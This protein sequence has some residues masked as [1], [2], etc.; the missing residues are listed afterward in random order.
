MGNSNTVASTS[1]EIPPSPSSSAETVELE[2]EKSKISIWWDIQNCKV[3]L[4][5]DPHSIAQ[6]LTSALVNMKYC[7]PV[8][9]S[10]YGDTNRLPASVHQAL[11]I[12]GI[13]LNHVSAG[14]KDASYKKMLMDML[15]WAL[16]NPAPANYL[17]ISGD[18]DFSN[19]L[20]QLRMRRYNIL[21]AQPTKA[22]APL[23]AAATSVWLWAT[24]CAGGPPLTKDE[25]SQLVQIQSNCLSETD[26]KPD[27]LL[28]DGRTSETRQKGKQTSD[29]LLNDGR[30]SETRQKGKQRCLPESKSEQKSFNQIPSHVKGPVMDK[31]SQK[32]NK[33]PNDLVEGQIAVILFALETLK[34][35]MIMPTDE[36]LSDCIRYG[37]PRHR[38]TDVKKAIESA[39]DL[40]FVVKKSLGNSLQ[41]YVGKNDKLW[42]CVNLWGHKQYPLPTWREVKK[43][44]L[45][46]DGRS[47]I[48]ASECKYEAAIIIKRMCLKEHPL[49]EIL[50]IVQL[51]VR[52]KKWIVHNPSGWQPVSIQLEDHVVYL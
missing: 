13:T 45:S 22:S 12:T 51:M 36:N 52:A 15:F 35:E 3:P 42:N 33:H 10:V 50:H 14:V 1:G 28:N 38:N 7:G 49:G 47:A 37:D 18:Q 11:N 24:L 48:M 43:F 44:M 41:L 30:T 40:Q 5:S 8:S 31:T 4:S 32:T 26:T 9:I 20:H 23:V 17:L 16:D 39:L 25:I 29:S 6:N 46:S 2:Y 19:A 21:L 34:T 27:I